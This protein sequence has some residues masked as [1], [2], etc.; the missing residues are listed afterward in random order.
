MT[1][2][3]GVAVAARGL[4]KS[5]GDVRAL[6]DAS[7][8]VHEGVIAGLLGRNGAG[9]TTALQMISGQGRPTSGTVEVFG[10]RPFEDG[11]AMRSMCFVKE[12]QCYPE[13]FTVD[14]ILGSAS[15]LLPGWDA[16]FAARLVE[17]FNL[18][19]R[20]RV[21]K[22]S[23]GMTS[24]VGIVIGLA[25]RAPLTLFD[26]PYLGLD[27]VARQIFYDELLADYT[28]HPRTVVLSTH[29]I[30]E[31]ADLLEQVVLIDNGRVLLDDSTENLRQRAIV[32][33]G[34][35]AVIDQLAAGGRL[36]SH[37]AMGTMA[38]ASIEGNW[39]P[40]DLSAARSLGVEVE[41]ASLQQLIV[42]ATNGVSISGTR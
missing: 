4:T 25:S 41:Q 22:L 17:R 5:Y 7:F 35:A 31:V 8:T 15:D 34:P 9:K 23:R 13:G 38:R 10:R 26:E 33:T 1:D 29:L 19:R 21:K 6:S 24:A 39:A 14:M 18:P 27:A 16:E 28:A 36:L 32:A 12:G 20:R 42:G 11:P 30:D 40:R 37:E 3:T 2:E